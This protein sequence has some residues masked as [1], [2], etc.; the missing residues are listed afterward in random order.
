MP[1]STRR[2]I[3][4]MALL[5]QGREHQVA[6]QRS[7]HRDLGGSPVADLADH[8]HVRVLAGSPAGRGEGHVDL[9][10][11]PVWLMPPGGIRSDPRR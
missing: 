5:V 8:H 1:M 6:G 2:V 9:G 7:S 11:D 4:P 3:A 10:V